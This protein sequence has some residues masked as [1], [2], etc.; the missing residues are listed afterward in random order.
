MS[1]YKLAPVEPTEDMCNKGAVHCKGNSFTAMM[2]YKAMLE[3]APSA[4]SITI[5]IAEY[6]A[7][8]K[9]AERWKY[10]LSKAVLTDALFKIL[11]SDE[12]HIN[13]AIDK[14]KEI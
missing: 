10:V 5:P 3:D 6:E 13:N 4:E 11:R 1:D 12:R 2:V 8:K 7:I 9:D 14:A